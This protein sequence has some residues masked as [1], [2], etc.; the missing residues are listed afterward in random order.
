MKTLIFV[1]TCGVCWLASVAT[2][3]AQPGQL[4]AGPSGTAA[5][6]AEGQVEEGFVALFDGQTLDGWEGKAD[7]FRVT[8]GAIVAGS[9]E[10]KIPNNEFLCTTA[11]YG[12]F[13]LRLEVKLIG[14]GN[15]AGVQ[16]RSQRV[17]NDHEVSGYQCDAGGAWDR[18]VWGGLYD[19]SRRRKMLAEAP[20]PALEKWIKPGDWNELRIRAVG[21]RIE[22]FLNGHQTVDYTESDAEI[23]VRGVI[24]LQIHSGPPTEAWYRRIRIK[25]LDP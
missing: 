14:E 22:L 6:Q 16:F 15:N 2:C 12:D 5:T 17:P 25:P 3:G 4:L 21:K 23:P 24:G 20:R 7:Y 13:E 8:E 18:P 11:E 19:E 1:T 9:L 10:K